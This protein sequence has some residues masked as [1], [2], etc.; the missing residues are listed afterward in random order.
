MKASKKGEVKE[1]NVITKL[2]Q[3]A[4]VKKAVSMGS[5]ESEA[6]EIVE[7]MALAIERKSAA[8]KPQ[9]AK[10][11]KKVKSPQQPKEGDLFA[12]VPLPAVK[13][14][15]PLK[16]PAKKEKKAEFAVEISQL[17][18]WP[19]V[20]RSLPNEIIRSALFNAK[21]RNNKRAMLKSEPIAIIGDGRITYRG[22]ELRQD[23]EKV[24]LQLVHLARQHLAGQLVEFTA[25][26]FCLAIRWKINKQSYKRLKES[27]RRMQ[28]TGL[29]VYSNRLDR[30]VSLSMIPFFEY[31]DSE[32]QKNLPKWRVRIAPELVELFGNEHYTRIEWE[33]RLRLPDGLATWLHGYLA[34]HRVPHPIKIET[35]AHGAGIKTK[36]KPALRRL[37]KT[38]LENLVT[39]GFLLSFDLSNDLVTVKRARTK[40]S[41]R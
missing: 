15:L 5:N 8:A 30:G 26:S 25:H 19:D 32:T 17:P 23:D 36:D 2:G 9:P 12:D 3:D 22:E 28:A 29:D 31:E 34:S 39:S 27:L 14:N 21:N 41:D 20:A 37:I 40:H 1:P 11:P 10:L 13:A 16:V 33:Q 18:F 7:K 38:A 35:V 24:W 6:R 4:W